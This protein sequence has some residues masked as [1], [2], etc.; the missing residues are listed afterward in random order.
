MQFCLFPAQLPPPSLQAR[1]FCLSVASV[2]PPGLLTVL[3]HAS[4]PLQIGMRLCQF[5][6]EQVRWNPVA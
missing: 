1:C 2:P 3:A 5:A 6:R 4:T